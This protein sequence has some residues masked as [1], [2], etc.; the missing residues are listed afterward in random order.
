MTGF[1]GN[2][3]PGLRAGIRAHE[4]S[5]SIEP[6][7]KDIKVTEESRSRELADRQRYE[8]NFRPSVFV[9]FAPL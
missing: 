8:R 3:E 9:A 7:Q 5:P 2:A 4:G 6:G 1:P